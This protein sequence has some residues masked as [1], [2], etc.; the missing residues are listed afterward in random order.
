MDK[1]IIVFVEGDTDE[2]FFKQLL[3]YYSSVSKKPLPPCKIC[4]LR[5]ITRYSSKLLARLK[6]DLIPSS[7]QNGTT[8]EAVCCSYDTDVFDAGNPQIVNWDALRRS[9]LKMGVQEFIQL[10]INSSIEDWIL[11]DLSGVCSFLRLKVVPKSLKGADG[12]AKLTYLYSRVNKVYQKGYQTKSLI[13][14]LDMAAIRE[15]NKAVL[16]ELEKTLGLEI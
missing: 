14:A 9:V 6:N 3:T 1:Q 16:K 7:R 15:K 11:C 10:G 8:I 5:G 2:V 4:N 13:A 12:N